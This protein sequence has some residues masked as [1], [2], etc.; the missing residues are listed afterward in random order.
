MRRHLPIKAGIVILAVAASTLFIAPPG[1]ALCGD[2]VAIGTQEWCV[3]P[4]E[5]YAFCHYYYE[6]E[7]FIFDNKLYR[8]RIQRCEGYSPCAV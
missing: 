6:Y 2:C 3:S 8:S 1:A 7:Y 5:T 4:P